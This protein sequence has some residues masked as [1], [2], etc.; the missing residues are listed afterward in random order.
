MMSASA[1]QVLKMYFDRKQAARPGFSMRTFAKDL[2][3]TPSFVSECLSGKKSIPL[4]RIP[5]LIDILE[6]DDVAAEHLKRALILENLSQYGL[7]LETLKEEKDVL[8]F[9]PVPKSQFTLLNPWYNIAIMDLTTCEG[10]KKDHEW[11]AK[12]LGL[13]RYQVEHSLNQ[14]IASGLLQETE[15]G[16]KKIAEQIRLSI[17]E[18]HSEI[19]KYHASMIEKAKQ[20]LLTKTS[21]T[22]FDLREISGV[23][24]AANPQQVAKARQIL[25]D[26]IH[27]AA[28]VLSQGPC[29]DLY[30]INI[31]LF[32][33]LKS[34]E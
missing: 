28:T 10:F 7:D 12:R 8:K 19:R 9:Q 25:V 21:K 31:Q 34:E 4:A 30:Q 29:T 17:N 6:L 22:A 3:V 23:T 27:E 20:E 14:L 24:I 5:E 16:Y 18:S 13:S 15:E 2:K 33:L 26:A 1:A 11:I 32:S